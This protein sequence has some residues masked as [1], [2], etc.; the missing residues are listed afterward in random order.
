MRAGVAGRA[1]RP[2]DGHD[3]RWSCTELVSR[4]GYQPRVPPRHRRHACDRRDRGAAV[5]CPDP[6]LR[7]RLHRASTCSTSS[8]ASSSPG[9]SCARSRAAGTIDLPRFYFRRVRRLLPAG[10]LVI[11]LTLIASYLILSPIRFPTVAGD[12]AWLL[13]CTSPTIDS[14]WRAPTTW[15][16]AAD[17]SPYQHFWSLAVEE[18]FYLIWPAL[19]L[20]SARL[21][22]AARVGFVLAGVTLASFLFSLYMTD[23]SAPW[24]FFSL[25]TRAWELGAGGLVAVGIGGRLPARFLPVAGLVGLLIVVGGVLFINDSMPYPGT[26]ALVPVLGTML[27][28]IGASDAAGALARGL[29]SRWPKFLGGISYSLYLWHWPLLILVPIA[30]SDDSLGLRVTLGIV[31]IAVRHHLDPLHRGA[32]PVRQDLQDARPAWRADRAWRRPSWSARP[33]SRPVTWHPIHS[34][35]DDG[36]DVAVATPRPRPTRRPTPAPV[37]TLGADADPRGHAVTVDTSGHSAT[38]DRATGHRAS[39]HRATEHSTT[40]HRASGHRASGHSATEH[41]A[42]GDSPTAT[43]S[44]TPATPAPASACP[45]RHPDRPGD[46]RHR[47]RP[48]GDVRRPATVQRRRHGNALARPGHRGTHRGPCQPSTDRAADRRAGHPAPTPQPTPCRPPST[49]P[50]ANGR[51]HRRVERTCGANDRAGAVTI[52]ARAICRARIGRTAD[53]GTADARAQPAAPPRPRDGR[54]SAEGPDAASQGRQ[55]RPAGELRR[56]LPPRLRRGAAGRLRLRTRR[57]QR[58]RWSCS[59]THMPPSGCPPSRISPTF[60]TGGSS[61]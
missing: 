4:K 9:C 21:V 40:E 36:P 1:V 32:V 10:L 29:G 49:H 54:S 34:A 57:T 51:A 8:P 25:P 2:R 42:S 39:G 45:P 26:A 38:D 43:P 50:A 7:R 58:R 15:P 27:L 53:P 19:I 23:I 33:R 55:G 6:G 52:D 46:C 16:S 44:A 12:G 11:L 24:A 20:L 41:R 14:R 30:L 18:Q 17:P 48:T 61:R 22:G 60:A 28:I 5:P 31:A 59:A 13:R 47:R 37:V 56:R 35:N 3:R